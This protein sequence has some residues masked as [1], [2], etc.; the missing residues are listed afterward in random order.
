MTLAT[1]ADV[2]TL[3][4]YLPKDH[5]EKATWCSP[6]GS[7]RR[8]EAAIWSTSRWRCAWCLLS[9]EGVECRLK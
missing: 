2:R 4:G 8:R 5:R 3:L 9:M 6:I 1:L 7:M